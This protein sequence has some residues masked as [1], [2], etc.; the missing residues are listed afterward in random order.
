MNPREI[1]SALGEDVPLDDVALHWKDSMGVLPNG[2]PS[3]LEAPMILESRA[4]C[5]FGPDV[6]AVLFE[7]AQRIAQHEALRRLAWHCQWRLF[8]LREPGGLKDWPPLESS[9]GDRC[10]VFYLLAGLSMV[11]RVRAYHRSLGI[12]ES[13]TRDTCSQIHDYCR[14]YKRGHSGRPGLRLDHIN[15][16]CHYPRNPYFRIGRLEYWLKPNPCGPVVYRHDSTGHALALA[17]DGERFT[18][19]GYAEDPPPEG[20]SVWTSAL[21]VGSDAVSGNPISPYGVA[22]PEPVSLPLATWKRVLGQGDCILDTHIPASGKLT[23]EATL[24]SMRAAVGFFGRHFRDLSPVAFT[25][26]SWI[27][28]NHLESLLPPTSNLVLYQRELYLFPIPSL[29]FS[30]LSFVFS[31]DPFDP[32]TASGKTRLQRAILDFLAG[33]NRWHIGGMFFLI[34][35]LEHLGTQHYRSRWPLPCIRSRTEDMREG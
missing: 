27:F 16:L 23:H 7:T 21:T 6:D 35:D 26:T 14:A 19:Q 15:W 34:Q 3:F 1:L 22:L 13:V 24:Q 9:L 10:G 28:S 25:S 32:R 8:S 2:T 11:P 31:G 4:W 20:P 33:G 17:G 5:G 30:G 29:E 18:A 12:P